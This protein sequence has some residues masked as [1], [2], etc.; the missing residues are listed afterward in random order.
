MQQNPSG[1]DPNL[2]AELRAGEKILWWAYPNP[3]RRMRRRQSNMLTVRL[4]IILAVFLFIV[5]EDITSIPDWSFLEAS[6]V[7]ILIGANAVILF[8]LV[9]VLLIYNSSLRVLGLLRYTVYAI[10]NQR[11]LMITARPGKAHGV[12]SYSK[13]DIGTISRQEGQGGWG[14][15]T[16]GTLRPATVGTRTML[17]QSRFSGIPNVRQAE[18]IMFRTFKNT[19]EPSPPAPGE[20][21]SYEQ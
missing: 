5:Y 10:T 8:C 11:A 1:I 7:L 14:D 2:L 16:F 19:I 4:A 15:L 3:K 13:D 6:T 18:E 12:I 9:Y 17:T 21:V 20:R